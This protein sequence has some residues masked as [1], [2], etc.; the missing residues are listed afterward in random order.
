MQTLVPHPET[1]PR[2]SIHNIKPYTSTPVKPLSVIDKALLVNQQLL[3]L[4]HRLRKNTFHGLLMFSVW[5]V[6]VTRLRF[7]GFRALSLAA[8]DSRL[9]QGFLMCS[10]RVLTKKPK[11]LYV[12]LVPSEAKRAGPSAGERLLQVVWTGYPEVPISLN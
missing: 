3:H 8:A 4:N 11:F 10:R 2:L 7:Q 12:F 9:A 1:T 5:G 6:R